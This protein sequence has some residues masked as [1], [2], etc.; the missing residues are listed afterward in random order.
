MKDC[1]FFIYINQ[2]EETNTTHLEIVTTYSFP[3]LILA[4]RFYICA[5]YMTAIWPL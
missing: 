2:R 4:H 5:Y 3:F 1:I